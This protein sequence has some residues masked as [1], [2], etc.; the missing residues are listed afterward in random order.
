MSKKLDTDPCDWIAPENLATCLGLRDQSIADQLYDCQF[1]REHINQRVQMILEPFPR[2]LSD[3]QEALFEYLTF[4]GEQALSELSRKMT[5][6][7]N[8]RAILQ[9]TNGPLLQAII[10]WCGTS[11]VIAPIRSGFLPD[12]QSFI[13][14][15][16]ASLENFDLYSNKI[17]AYLLGLLPL[18]YIQ[19]LQLKTKPGQLQEPIHFDDDDPDRICFLNY[20]LMAHELEQFETKWLPIIRSELQRNKKEEPELKSSEPDKV[21]HAAEEGENV[22]D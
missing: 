14:F 15:S 10:D 9:T 21:F 7:M 1:L 17:E 19:R 3:A 2:D 12:F 13:T 11:D 22:T 6:L 16:S 20:A 5:L 18:F 4:F 8:H